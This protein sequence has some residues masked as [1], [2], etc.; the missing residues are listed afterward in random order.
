MS[1]IHWSEMEIIRVS[2]DSSGVDIQLNESL[3]QIRSDFFVRC[4]GYNESKVLPGPRT[5]EMSAL[6]S[7]VGSCIVSVIW[8]RDLTIEI[9]NGVQIVV[10]PSPFGHRETILSSEGKQAFWDDF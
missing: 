5:A 1:R 9:D 2:S 6:W 7:S 8:G 3:V 4:A 10:P